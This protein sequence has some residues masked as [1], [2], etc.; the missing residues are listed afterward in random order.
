[1]FDALTYGKGSSVLR[2]IEQYL[3]E[4]QFP[5]GSGR[6]PPHA[7]LRQHRDEPTCGRDS[8]E[9]PVS[10]SGRSWTPGS[11]RRGSRRS[12][13]HCPVRRHAPPAAALPR[14]SPTRPTRPCG[15]FPS[16][17][18]ASSDGQP[19]TK[20]LLL[21]DASSGPWTSMGRSTGWSST[22]GATASTGFRMRTTGQ[23][24]A[25]QHRPARRQRALRPHL[26]H[27]GDGRVRS[28]ASR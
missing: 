9:P 14:S 23:G 10:T 13:C 19:S 11:C 21:E 22:P 3:G 20:K 1:M 7:R 15:R 8:T 5:A 27:V 26:G 18:V 12:T 25:S 24:S 16:R 4:E 2:Q 6:L 17:S 28:G